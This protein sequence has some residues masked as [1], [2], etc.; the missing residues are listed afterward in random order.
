VFEWE[1]HLHF[2][3]SFQIFKDSH[4]SGELG[5][6]RYEADV[7]IV[8]FTHLAGLDSELSNVH[9]ALVGI[10]GLGESFADVSLESLLANFLWVLQALKEFEDG[11]IL[12]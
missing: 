4:G 11:L 5:L 9:E 10:L 2:Q 8:Q 3:A 7:F 12:F 6:R 1:V